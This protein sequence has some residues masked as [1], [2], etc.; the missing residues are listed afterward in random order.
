MVLEILK[1]LREEGM[2][3]IGI[4]HDTKLLESVTDSV[5]QVNN[6]VRQGFVAG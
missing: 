3:M 1:E 6:I 4:F 5:Y 2:T